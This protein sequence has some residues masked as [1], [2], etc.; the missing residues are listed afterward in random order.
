MIIVSARSR[1]Q[2]LPS[3]NPHGV[4]RACH[5]VS[6][7]GRYLSGSLWGGDL[8]LG[9]GAPNWAVDYDRGD[10]AILSASPG[11]TFGGSLTLV[12]ATS[13]DPAFATPSWPSFAPDSKGIAYGAGVHSRGANGASEH[14]GALFMISRAGGIATRLDTACASARRCYLPN[15]SPYDVGGYFWL[16]FY[17]FQDYGNTRV[18]TKGTGRRQLWIT[19][20][21]KS[22]LGTGQDPSSVPYWLPD[23]DVASQ[24]MSAFWAL[25]TPI[26]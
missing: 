17:S 4:L 20:I 8:T 23:Q 24:N 6:K 14:P 5:T 22:K 25:P 9:G 19:A 21:D 11:D 7:D 1:Q 13:V 12:P 15:F 3:R 2:P 18:G 16:V 10:L 26:Q